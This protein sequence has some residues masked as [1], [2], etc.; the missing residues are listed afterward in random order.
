MIYVMRIFCNCNG[1]VGY[2]W[3]LV[4]GLLVVCYCSG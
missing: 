1:M 3:C 4:V 2:V